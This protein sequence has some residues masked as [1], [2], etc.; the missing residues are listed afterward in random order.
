MS[1]IGKDAFTG[2]GLEGP[3]GT[4]VYKVYYAGTEEEWKSLRGK[5]KQAGLPY[6]ANYNYVYDN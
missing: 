2:L 1:E 6:M 3:D 5:S 4:V